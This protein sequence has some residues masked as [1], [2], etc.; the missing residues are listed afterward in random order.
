LKLTE[1]K[2]QSKEQP[3]NGNAK[4]RKSSNFKSP[5][6][7][8]RWHCFMN[9]IILHT[10]LQTSVK[11]REVWAQGE[12]LRSIKKISKVQIGSSLRTGEQRL[13]QPQRLHLRIGGLGSVFR[14]GS[15]GEWVCF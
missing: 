5:S 13:S 11:I 9:Q 4:L 12:T 10:R 7:L 14:L 1:G 3:E 2:N 8:P 15:K 6:L